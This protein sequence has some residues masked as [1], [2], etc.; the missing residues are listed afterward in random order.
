MDNEVSICCFYAVIR[1]CHTPFHFFISLG[2]FA[3]W[4]FLWSKME[5]MKLASRWNEE[6]RLVGVLPTSEAGRKPEAGIVEA[7]KTAKWQAV[8]LPWLRSIWCLILPGSNADQALQLVFTEHFGSPKL[9]SLLKH[10][11]LIW[12]IFPFLFFWADL[13]AETLSF[14]LPGAIWFPWV[15]S[16]SEY[17]NFS[18]LYPSIFLEIFS[19][20][21]KSQIQNQNKP[22]SFHLMRTMTRRCKFQNSFECQFCSKNLLLSTTELLPVNW[23]ILGSWR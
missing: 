21:K 5:G 12:I 13:K 17:I 7:Q 3:C 22:S 4:N 11:H 18:S 8:Q 23:E 1:N 14:L 2:L 15:F 9:I 6:Q 16:K 20:V 10:F 19:I